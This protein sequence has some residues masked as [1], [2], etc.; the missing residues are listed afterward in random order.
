M[1]NA[2]SVRD[3]VI[4]KTGHLQVGQFIELGTVQPIVVSLEPEQMREVIEWGQV[5][6]VIVRNIH[7]AQMNVGSQQGD[8]C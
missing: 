5:R 7:I 4:G 8:V 3:L 2:F 1:S 6:H